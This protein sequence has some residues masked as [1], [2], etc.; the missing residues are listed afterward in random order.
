VPNAKYD[1]AHGV[2]A[3]L[4]KDN[5]GSY[6]FRY[7]VEPEMGVPEG[8]TNEVQ[9]G[10]QCREIRIWEN[11]TK[12]ILKKAIIRSVVDESAEFA[13]INAYNKHVLKVKID[14]DA[15]NGYKEYLQFT[16]DVDALLEMN[17]NNGEI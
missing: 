8:K 13:I 7:N 3:T 2:P 17:N 9:V 16:E 5:D 14:T 1:L 12:G 15:V 6:L 11:P 10:W 4:K